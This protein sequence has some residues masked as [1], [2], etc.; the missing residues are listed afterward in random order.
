MGTFSDDE[1]LSECKACDPGFYQSKIG[2]TKC[3]VCPKYHYCSEP[4]MSEPKICENGTYQIEENSV[5]CE[6]CPSG[7]ACQ[8]GEIEKCKAGF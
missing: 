2:Q 8:N 6:I 1:K 4:Q 7:H 3:E 5:K